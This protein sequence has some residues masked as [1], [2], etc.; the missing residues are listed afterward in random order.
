[1]L[2]EAGERG[3]KKQSM[4][5]TR[6]EAWEWSPCPG[7][8]QRPGFPQL[9]QTATPPSSKVCAASVSVLDQCSE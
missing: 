6:Q 8:G 2:I 5:G 7:G 1:M 3:N 4:D 9:G